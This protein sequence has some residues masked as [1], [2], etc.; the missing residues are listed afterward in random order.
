ME[1]W[2]GVRDRSPLFIYAENSSV[3]FLG[4]GPCAI[5]QT[6]AEDANGGLRSSKEASGDLEETLLENVKRLNL[7]AGGHR[8][9]GPISG[10]TPRGRGKRRHRTPNL[11]YSLS[12]P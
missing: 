12:C 3:L 10:G 2:V 5:S 11:L 6:A 4:V 1:E 8:A 9:C 7:C